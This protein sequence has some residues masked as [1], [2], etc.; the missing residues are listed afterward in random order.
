M[1]LTCKCGAT[2]ELISY[3]SDAA[4]LFYRQ[5]ESCLQPEQHV[6]QHL[7]LDESFWLNTF[8]GAAMQGLLI[9]VDEPRYRNIADMA[10]KQA[11]AL[12]EEVKEHEGI[13]NG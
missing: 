5:H 4:N 10:V 7:N 13:T 6:H 11:L 3:V 9:G 12:L 1:K 2:L 8:A